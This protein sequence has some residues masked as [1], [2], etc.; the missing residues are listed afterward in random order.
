MI[1]YRYK[2]YLLVAAILLVFTMGYFSCGKRADSVISSLPDSLYVQRGDSIS[3]A[4]FDTLSKTLRYV[5]QT[6]GADSAIRFCNEQAYPITA[7]YASSGVHVI[8]TSLKFRNPAN[9]PDEL[10]NLILHE[11]KATQQAGEELKPVIRHNK[12]G[13]IHYF[14]P[15][16]LQGMCITCHGNPASDIP[17]LVKNALNTLYPNDQAIGY[18]VGDLRGM[19]HIQ[20]KP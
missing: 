15:I 7:I 12:N 5:M 18:Q 17:D 19:W 2:K 16:L 8:R 10:E 9:E 4:T 11:F 3:S 6:A 13:T 20:F 1:T 14:K